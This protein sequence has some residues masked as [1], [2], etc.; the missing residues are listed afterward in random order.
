MATAR[1]RS[2]ALPWLAFNRDASAYW[3]RRTLPRV[4]S[5]CRTSLTSSIT[6]CRKSRKT[7]SIGLDAPAVTADMVSHPLY[8]HATN[9]LSYSSWSVRWAHAWRDCLS[10]PVSQNARRLRESESPL[11]QQRIGPGWFRF[12]VKSCKR[13]CRADSRFID[14]RER[15]RRG[16]SVWVRW[17][18]AASQPFLTASAGKL[19][20]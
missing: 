5:T 18:R 14:S 13:N 15:S 6:T 16:A 4:E 17:R 1:N 7:L 12:L 20:Q 11:S 19:L 2:A 10:A 8:S 3:W 9:D